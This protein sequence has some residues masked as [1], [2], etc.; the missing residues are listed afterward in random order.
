[1]PELRKIKRT[2]VDKRARIIA[3]D[4]AVDCTVV[5]L[6]NL[7]A[8]LRLVVDTSL[9]DRFELIFDSAHFRRNCRVRWRS[10]KGLGVEFEIPSELPR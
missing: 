7:G 1:M 6:T 3:P 4:Y 10:D 9:P 2:K 5:D 8:G